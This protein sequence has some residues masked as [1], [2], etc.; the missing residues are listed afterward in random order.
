MDAIDSNPFQ[1]E[2]QALDTEFSGTCPEAVVPF[3]PN[4]R[5]RHSMRIEDFLARVVPDGNHVAIC[6]KG[7]TGGMAQRFFPRD[8]LGD[9]AGYIRWAVKQRMDVWYGVASY[10]E[11]ALDE[12]KVFR[13]ER[14]QDN[15]QALQ[16]L[17]YD[18][19]IS[20][21]DDGKAPGKAFADEVEFETWLAAFCAATGLPR[22]SIIVNSGYGRH[23]YWVFEDPLAPDDWQLYADAFKTALLAHGAKGDVSITTDSARILRPP[24]SLNYKVPAD[25][26]PVEVLEV[27]GEIPNDTLCEPLRPFMGAAKQH[28]PKTNTGNV[29]KLAGLTGPPPALAQQRQSTLTAA[30][31]AGIPPG[32][33]HSFER[34][35]TKCPQV[36]RSLA[37]GGEGDP[38]P[39]WYT[40]FLNLAHFC[41]DG[42][43]YAHEIS[44]GD[45]RYDVAKVDAELQ[46]VAKEHSGKNFGAPLCKKF[47]EMRPGICQG[48]PHSGKVTTPYSL[49]VEPDATPI[50]AGGAAIPGTTAGGQPL[51]VDPRGPQAITDIPASLQP[52]DALAIM[53]ATFIYTHNW[54]G[55]SLIAH[56]LPDGEIEGTTKRNLIGSLENRQVEIEKLSEDGKSKKIYVPLVRYWLTNSQR[57]EV[58][59]VVYDP[60]SRQSHS[61]HTMNLWRG[62]AP[63]AREGGWQLMRD[64][65]YKIICRSDDIR[66]TYL[67]KWMAH[68]VQYPGTAPGSVVIMRSKSEG[69]GKSLVILWM[70][71]IFGKHGISIDD[72]EQLLGRFNEYLGNKSFVGVGEMGRP[73]RHAANKF[74]ERITGPKW[75]LERKNG[76]VWEVPNIAHIM[77]ASNEAWIVAAGKSARRWFIL[78][79]D[80][81]YAN[82][83]KY[84]DPLRNEANNG[85]IEAML[86][87]LLRTD[88]TGF[89]TYQVPRTAALREQQLRSAETTTQWALERCNEGA[90]TLV[91]DLM[92]IGRPA[93]AAHPHQPPTGF[94]A[95][96]DGKVLYQDYKMWC[97][98][99]RKP[100]E[101]HI[102]FGKWLTGVGIPAQPSNGKTYRDIP[103]G[104]DFAIVVC[105]GAG[106]V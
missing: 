42:E 13:G 92:N 19:D 37:T 90:F 9:A 40:G 75:Q 24:E 60:E 26:K 29:V 11:A 99:M 87:D 57:R 44:K 86:Y 33:T 28:A 61:G 96:R 83:P 80:D 77:M 32:R 103:N 81:R 106:I 25:P 94:G 23:C 20:R 8:K 45:P 7:Q 59:R 5:A 58:D 27:R 89:D 88:L 17:W 16:V 15:T 46:R 84:F 38:Y 91:S 74:R 85:G 101:T 43:H 82:D 47:D 105:R 76:P 98:E 56:C 35:A 31:Q 63:K 65:I 66:F 36:K 104:N 50:V 41:G 102:T 12:K 64:H 78:D 53:N 79:V 51:I 54:G 71:T 48:C 14:T 1:I 3:P 97:A 39:L 22:P 52:H 30:A 68:S 93:A 62:F 18:A 2:A 34:I 49:G 72:P 67:L 10:R 21:P 70:L 4:R 55:D 69:T 95:K 6:H 100:A 73:D